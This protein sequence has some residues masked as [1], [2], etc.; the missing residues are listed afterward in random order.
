MLIEKIALYTTG[1]KCIKCNNTK[2]YRPKNNKIKCPKCK[3]RYGLKKLSKE[4][5]CL[6]FFSL[7]MTANKT[8]KELNINYNTVLSTYTY[9]REKI[10]RYQLDKFQL[11]K[12]ENDCDDKYFV[13]Y[14]KY[15]RCGSSSNN[16]EVLGLLE[17]KEQ[18]FITMFEKLPT[19]FEPIFFESTKTGRHRVFDTYTSTHTMLLKIFNKDFTVNHIIEFPDRVKYINRFE[20]FWSFTKK[21]LLK[22]RGISKSN[23]YLYLKE[24]EFRYNNR[25][26]NIFNLL[27]KIIFDYNL[28]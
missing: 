5:W 16:I 17:R 1:S 25:N 9:F 23:L 20:G 18:I 7:E 4:L 24:I 21:Q 3:S 10:T 19:P 2:L 14:F 8:S 11:L 13:G 27:N 6:Y 22:Y 15:H 26:S 12:E 28:N